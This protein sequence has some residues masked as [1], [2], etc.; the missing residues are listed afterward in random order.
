MTYATFDEVKGKIPKHPIDT[1]TTPNTTQATTIHAEVSGELNL[2]LANKGVGIP[3]ISDGSAVQ[4]AFADS[5][6]GWEAHGAC[7]RILKAMFGGS[8]GANQEAAWSFHLDIWEKAIKGLLDGSLLPIGIGA[9]GSK[10]TPTSLP[11]DFPETMPDDNVIGTPRFSV[12][13]TGTRQTKF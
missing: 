8:V 12:Q 9:T 2:V 7:A 3:F 11:V 1:T 10:I 13:H 4:D 5:L 6:Q